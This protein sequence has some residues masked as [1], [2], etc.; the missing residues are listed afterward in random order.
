MSA[1]SGFATITVAWYIGEL[2]PTFVIG[3]APRLAAEP[4]DGTTVQRVTAVLG[5]LAAWVADHVPALIQAPDCMAPLGVVAGLQRAGIEPDV[6][7]L[8]AHGDFNTWETTPSGYLGGMP[9]AM[10]VGRGDQAIIDG[11]GIDP[12]PEGRVVLAGARD[13]D[14]G[15]EEALKG[16][17]IRRVALAEL[18]RVVRPGRPL[19]VHLDVDVVAP[20]EMPGLL[21]PALGGPRLAEVS[22]ALR[23][24]MVAAPNLVAIWVAHTYGQRAETTAEARRLTATLVAALAPLSSVAALDG[25]RSR[26]IES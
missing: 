21:Y 12:I 11:L 2:L 26:S 23:D 5:V 3:H 18:S 17:A 9:L 4:P 24:L 10:L 14:L 25:L 8:D 20:T 7:W 19:Y 6:V 15:E 1:A 16:S 22:E 13:L